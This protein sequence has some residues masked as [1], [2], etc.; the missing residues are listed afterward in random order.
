MRK[1][2]IFGFLF[3]LTVIAWLSSILR[4]SGKTA[5]PLRTVFAVS[6]TSIWCSV[7]SKKSETT[8]LRAQKIYETA[9]GADNQMVGLP[10]TVLCSVYDQWGKQDKSAECHSR[11][12]A[13]AP[14]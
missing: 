9:Y 7:I 12:A 11:L 1:N 6:P 3:C 8:L 2:A 14:K 4:S 5:R 10:L 13:L